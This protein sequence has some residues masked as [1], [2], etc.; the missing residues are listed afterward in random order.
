[1]LLQRFRKL[2]GAHLHFLKQTDALNGDHG[3]IGKGGD[4][5]DLSLGEGFLIQTGE[6]EHADDFAVA[7]Q[8][9]REQG[10]VAAKALAFAELIFRIG[11]N[12]RQVLH[13]AA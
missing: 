10:A 6:R 5:I 9:D 4:Q 2:A 11:Q 7:Q 3:L 8:R 12:V 13:L 1:L